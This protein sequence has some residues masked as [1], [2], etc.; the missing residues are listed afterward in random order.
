MAVFKLKAL[1][2]VLAI[3]AP[4]VAGTGV[5]GET[6]LSAQ[7]STDAAVTLQYGSATSDGTVLYTMSVC[8]V[9]HQTECTMVIS[10]SGEALPSV[11][12]NEP[13]VPVGG[14]P[15]V[16]AGGEPT[17]YHGEGMSSL[18]EGVP[19]P[20]ETGV[21]PTGASAVSEPGYSAPAGT[22]PGEGPVPV[23]V[24]SGGGEPVPIPSV[25]IS[26]T[27]ASGNPT[28]LTT[29]YDEPSVTDTA[30]VTGSETVYDTTVVT[31]T[32]TDSNP[33]SADETEEGTPTGTP[34]VTAT[35]AAQ[36][37]SPGAALAIAGILIAVVF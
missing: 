29:A 32:A 14:E 23:P 4:Y 11:A 3:V 26:T 20:S 19:A 15:S 30:T 18:S 7:I 5:D 16:P 17:T 8:A 6:A 1:A 10:T 21:E 24:P 33:S 28:V 34:S 9:T 37:L 12:T 27:D 22:S 36:T 35:G 13:S 25:I 31:G 2:S